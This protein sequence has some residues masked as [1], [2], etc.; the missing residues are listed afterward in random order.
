M[1]LFEKTLLI[2]SLLIVASA[3]AIFSLSVGTPEADNTLLAKIN[4]RIVELYQAVNGSEG[5]KASFAAH[6]FCFDGTLEQLALEAKDSTEISLV[7]DLGRDC[8]IVSG[9][10]NS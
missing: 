9:F 1:K 6:G 7:E 2:K 3:I 10:I 8:R 5:T 4:S